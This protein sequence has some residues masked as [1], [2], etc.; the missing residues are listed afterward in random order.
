M[1]TAAIY[2]LLLALGRLPDTGVKMSSVDCLS[3][4]AY[5]DDL[6]KLSSPVDGI[7]RQHSMVHPFLHSTGMRAN[8]LK[9]ST[10]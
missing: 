7:Q 5:D 8:P 2:S 1:F 9:C 4:A 10:M 6:N 3:S